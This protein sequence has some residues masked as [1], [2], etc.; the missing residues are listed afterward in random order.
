MR[1]TFWKPHFSLLFDQFQRVGILHGCQGS[2]ILENTQKPPNG[3]TKWPRL[4]FGASQGFPGKGETWVRPLGLSEGMN[5]INI[6]GNVTESTNTI[7]RNITA[8]GWLI[9]SLIQF[10]SRFV[11]LGCRLPARQYRDHKQENQEEH[12]K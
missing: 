3:V 8:A 6:E 5:M 7:C 1:L 11:G 2:D 10:P 12:N 4:L 9:R